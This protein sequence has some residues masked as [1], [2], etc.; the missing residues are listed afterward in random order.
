[1]KVHMHLLTGEDHQHS[2]DKGYTY[3]NIGGERE[4]ERERE[5]ERERERPQQIQRQKH[6]QKQ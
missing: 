1:M 6:Q 5:K 3:F 2:P 4:R